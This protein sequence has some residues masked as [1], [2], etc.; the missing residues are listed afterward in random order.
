MYTAMVVPIVGAT[1]KNCTQAAPCHQTQP[2]LMSSFETLTSNGANP[3]YARK[4]GA[5]SKLFTGP[6]SIDMATGKHPSP[7]AYP[8]AV[9]YLD[10][11]QKATIQ[12]WIDMYGF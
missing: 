12:M 5:M 11:T 3:T 10:A 4:P 7:A 2:P 8:Q 9:V 6:L 1:G